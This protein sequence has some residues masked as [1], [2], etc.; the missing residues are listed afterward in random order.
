MFLI[1]SLIVPPLIGFLLISLLWP[2]QGAV[3]SQLLIKSSLALG[4]GLGVSSCTFFLWSVVF[5]PSSAGFPIV[6]AALVIVL[7]VVFS[8]VRRTRK[9]SSATPPFGPISNLRT[10]WILSTCFYISLIAAVIALM[11]SSIKN[12]HGEWD[13]W[14]IWNMRARFIFRGG[15]HWTD[16]FSGLLYWSH[17]DYPLLVPG[18]IAR[19]WNYVGQETVIVPALVSML[20]TLATVGL[21]SSSVTV[22]RG[23]SQG[24]LA[25][26]TLLGTPLFIEQGTSQLVDI[27]LSFFFLA[28]IALFRLQEKL[29]E[30]NRRF[31]FLA[32]MAAGLSAWTKNEGLLFLGSIMVTHLMVRVCVREWKVYLRQ[33]LVFATGLAPVL[34]IFLYY[35]TQLA[36]PNDLLSA[37][38]SEASL[39]RLVDLSRYWVVG[40]AF[41]V[42]AAHFG[43][44]FFSVTFLLVSYLLLLGI[45]GEEKETPDIVAALMT[46]GTL[47]VGYF[48]AYI[49]IPYELHW[50]LTTSLS[51]LFLQLWPSLLLVFF[52][53]VKT[54]EQAM[55]L[56]PSSGKHSHAR[57]D[58]T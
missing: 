13:A 16:A 14:A 31:L 46:L 24:L 17:P 55:K 39:A 8:Y 37:L 26:L 47:L 2:I 4:L 12:P 35:K 10:H 42:E 32:G 6:E 50:S 7:T 18:L 45:N 34:T 44:G 38:G 9:D 28:T 20:F 21:L 40:K 49:I 1:L 56:L 48:F 58:G 29:V 57:A 41:A 23:K 33:M 19:C 54:P 27:P 15:D 11:L 5:Y 30:N 22:F 51:R 53:A 25:G 43:K 52:L 36:P 3:R